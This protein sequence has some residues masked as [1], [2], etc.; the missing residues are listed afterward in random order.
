[1]S[2]LPQNL[3]AKIAS[4][5]LDI[6]GHLRL[7]Q[8]ICK[9]FNFLTCR[10]PTCRA[11]L[12]IGGATDHIKSWMPFAKGS[13]S[14]PLSAVSCKKCQKQTCAGCGRKPM[15]GSKSVM[16]DKESGISVS[17]CCEDGKLFSAW[18]LLSA[19][20][21]VELAVQGQTSQKSRGRSRPSAG[22]GTGY[23]SYRDNPTFDGSSTRTYWIAEPIQYDGNDGKDDKPLGD[24]LKILLPLLPSSKSNPAPELFAMLR[25]SLLV[26]RLA[27]L[28]VNDSITDITKRKDLYHSVYAFL[29]VIAKHPALV[30]IILEQRPCKKESPGLQALGQE[31]KRK[32]LKVDASSAGYALS[33]AACV[34]KVV[35][36]AKAF[37]GLSKQFAAAEDVKTGDNKEAINLCIELLN[38]YGVI[39]KMA[40]AAMDWLAPVSRDEWKSYAEKNRVT[41]TDDVLQ[42]RHM[43]LEGCLPRESFRGGFSM[44]TGSQPGR[45]KR[46]WKE[47]A[48]LSTS[49]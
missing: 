39:K 1:M 6:D 17:A 44:D 11:H 34:H 28:I 10:E 33:L 35:P 41:F 27:A 29:S 3:D 47:L 20:D 14:M 42:G 40:P 8:Q 19:F 38:F 22:K 25:L 21:E 30:D 32:L 49:L 23:G 5:P 24:I 26:D 4:I 46:L 7:L 13:Q 18:I 48:D 37:A 31:A 15:M 45:M 36:H 12:F 2:T 9:R 43:A 16:I